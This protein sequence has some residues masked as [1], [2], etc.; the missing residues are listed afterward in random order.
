MLTKYYWNHELKI[1]DLIDWN[2]LEVKRKEDKSDS[3]KRQARKGVNQIVK[4]KIE[5]ELF[6]Y[7]VS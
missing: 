1:N 6:K 4:N 5:R 3:Y 7:C 2:I